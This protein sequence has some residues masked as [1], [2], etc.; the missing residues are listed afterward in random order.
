MQSWC[1]EP[2]K[3]TGYFVEA[4]KYAPKDPLGLQEVGRAQLLLQN[5]GAADQYLSNAM[6]AGAGADARLLR[7]EALLGGDQVQTA[8]TEMT[9]YLGG[10]DVK[11]MPFQVRR[12]WVQIQERM[13]VEAAFAKA[14]PKGDA[15]IDY[16][17]HLPPDLK[18]LEPASDQRQLDSI[19]SAV[20]KTVAEFFRN[21]PNTTSL[22][23]VHQEK[24]S[25]NYKAIE[26]LDQQFQYVCFTPAWA[27]GPGFDEYR[28]DSV[29][30]RAVRQSP[31]EGFMLT[32]GF[33]AASLLFHPTYQSQAAFRYVGRQKVNGRDTYVVAFAQLAAKSRLYG[34]FRVWRHEHDDFV[35][36]FGLG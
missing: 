8:N 24:L 30:I 26:T 18:G 28:A 23:Q 2:A 12:L 33:A 21:F 6:A 29:G 9:R 32:S 15:S 19:L 25:H 34:S 17:H 27:W 35:P 14:K 4:L 16:L 11:K 5:W 1:H 13:K 20:G 22:E 7:I 10:R 36:G 31:T 3:A